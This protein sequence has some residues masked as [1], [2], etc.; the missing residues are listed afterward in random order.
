MTVYCTGRSSRSGKPNPKR[1]ETIEET[2]EYLGIST[3]TV[4]RSWR[5]A[6]AWLYEELHSDEPCN[7]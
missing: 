3:M 5:R 4:S 2:A 1:P 6:K 7:D